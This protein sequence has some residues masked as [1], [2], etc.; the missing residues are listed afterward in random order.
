MSS[1]FGRLRWLGWLYGCAVVCNTALG[2]GLIRDGIGA[3][4]TGRGGTNIAHSDNGAVMLDN[5]AGIVN[6]EGR[7]F[8]ELGV[9]TLITDLT[10]SDPQNYTHNSTQPLP[11]PEIAWYHT[12][13]DK[14]WAFGIG[15]FIPAGFSASYQ[16]NNPVFGPGLHRYRSFGAYAKILPGIAFHLTDKLAIGAAF[17][18]GLTRVE[19]DGP[20]YMQS[21]PLA[22]APTNFDL[23]TVGAAPIWNIGLQ[24]TLSEQTTIGLA[25]N[26]DANFGAKGDLHA[27]VLGL[28]PFPIASDFNARLAITWPQSLGLGI[29]HVVAEQHRF[30]ADVIWYGW[31]N[32][33][34][35]FGLT[36]THASN[37][38]VPMLVGPTI[39]QSIPANWADTV[40]VRLG[41]EFFASKNDTFRLG[42]V[43]HPSPVPSN[44]LNP[45][46]DGVLEH[47]VSTGYTHR[48]NN[49]LFSLAYQ[50]SF[51]PT[52]YIK[53]SLIVGN[54]FAN[55]TFNAQAHWISLSLSRYF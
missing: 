30:S 5:P 8:A 53:E 35:N 29:K 11:I 43:Y 13:E 9:D 55:S 2:D 23:T 27:Q 18:L 40:S 20:F 33:F 50:Y 39:Y 16:M 37:P 31:H 45:Y 24:Y 15:A 36:L 3:I 51:G 38:L 54:D 1:G 46:L 34:D 32:A 12:S 41:Y 21:G 26:S 42:Y 22:G 4:S 14:S 10:Y 49:W 7:N 6:F 44:T 28:A 17:G 52:R 25:F 48:W 47:A 19:I